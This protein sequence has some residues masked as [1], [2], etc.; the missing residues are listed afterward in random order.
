MHRIKLL[1]IDDDI[2]M[3]RIAEEILSQFDLQVWGAS[4]TTEADDVLRKETV[5]MV[6]CDV[7][8][9]GEDGVTYCR[10]LR[11]SGF[12]RP[13]ILLSAAIDDAIITTSGATLCLP[14][15]FDV[16]ELHQR[17]VALGGV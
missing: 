5:D 9:P 13:V 3:L 17:I 16:R 10:R 14:K 7:Q 6:V 12:S 15:P 1:F 4:S 11:A 8:M 2:T